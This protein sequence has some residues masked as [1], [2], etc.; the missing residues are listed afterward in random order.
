MKKKE[1][2][3]SAEW[4]A[5][6]DSYKHDTLVSQHEEAEHLN[7]SPALSKSV[8][9]GLSFNPARDGK[10]YPFPKGPI[11]F[12]SLSTAGLVATLAYKCGMPCMYCQSKSKS[13]KNKMTTSKLPSRHPVISMTYCKSGRLYKS[14]ALLDKYQALIDVVAAQST[15]IIT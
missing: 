2:I 13:F 4:Q 15:N 12:M 11:V 1:K 3:L 5:V 14:V 8:L 9:L 6:Y 7:V 10:S